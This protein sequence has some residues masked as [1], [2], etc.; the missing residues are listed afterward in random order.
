[1]RKQIENKIQQKFL[2]IDNLIE[3]IERYTERG[4]IIFNNIEQIR[5][6]YFEAQTPKEKC[7]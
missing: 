3:I 1:M 5:N 2:L 6:Y 4:K 7:K